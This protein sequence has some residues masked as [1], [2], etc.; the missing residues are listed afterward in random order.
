MLVDFCIC[1]FQPNK[2]RL[3]ED[4]CHFLGI[5]WTCVDR[6][7]FFGHVFF[8]EN[9]EIINH[10]LYSLALSYGKILGFISL[11]SFFVLSSF[12]ITWKALEEFHISGKFKLKHFLIRRS[13]RIWPL[14]FLIVFLGFFIEYMGAYY[15]QE[16]TTL[17][18][19]WSFFLFILNYDMII[20]GYEF[21]FFILEEI[22]TQHDSILQTA[23]QFAT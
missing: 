1:Q 10:N 20:N 19:F 13:L 12:L 21:L 11:D 22:K 2:T 9:S 15:N 18:S 23:L 16:I 8:S 4:T 6:Q 17:P 14:Y 3:L 7:L 5:C